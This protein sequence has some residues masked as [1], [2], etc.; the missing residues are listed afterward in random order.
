MLNQISS[1]VGLYLPA[2]TTKSLSSGIVNSTAVP[3]IIGIVTFLF[4]VSYVALCTI[5]V[6]EMSDV[7]P[8][9]LDTSTL[10]VVS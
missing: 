2:F 7:T 1:V 6:I 9:L 5:P 4:V 3:P 10:F 8:P